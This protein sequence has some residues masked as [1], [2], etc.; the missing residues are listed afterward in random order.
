MSEGKSRWSFQDCKRDCPTL[1]G[2]LSAEWSG[3]EWGW[4]GGIKARPHP[5]IRSNIVRVKEEKRERGSCCHLRSVLRIHRVSWLYFSVCTARCSACVTTGYAFV[6]RSRCCVCLFVSEAWSPMAS[7]VNT[8][9]ASTSFRR[10][11]LQSKS[12]PG[13]N[14]SNKLTKVAKF[15]LKHT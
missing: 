12:C 13:S 4:V 9:S 1:N 7:C 15:F 6:S 11:N 10:R 8:G 2:L 5:D 14:A 3:V